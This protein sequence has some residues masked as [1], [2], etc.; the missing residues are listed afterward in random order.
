M[1]VTYLALD[2]VGNKYTY[3]VRLFFLGRYFLNIF[4]YRVKVFDS[5]MRL[6]GMGGWLWRSR[7]GGQEVLSVGFPFSHNVITKL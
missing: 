6:E 3:I 5:S 2:I 4:E 7:A 1:T